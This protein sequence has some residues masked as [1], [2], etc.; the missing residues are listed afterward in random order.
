MKIKL[1]DRVR[2]ETEDS[3]FEGVIISLFDKYDF[4][5]QSLTGPSR[6]IVQ[7][8]DGICLIKNPARGVIVERSNL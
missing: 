3:L 4:Q 5:R 8:E 2:F 6:C 7:N 1:L